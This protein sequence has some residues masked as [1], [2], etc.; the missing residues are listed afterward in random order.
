MKRII[1]VLFYNF[2]LLQSAEVNI[3]AFY[4]VTT[5]KSR[6]AHIWTAIIS[7]RLH[8]PIYE[9][10]SQKTQ[11]ELSWLIHP[12]CTDTGHIFYTARIVWNYRKALMNF[13]SNDT[14]KYA[15]VFED[16][17]YIDT[18]RWQNMNKVHFPHG[19]DAL[20]IGKKH[21]SSSEEF[22]RL[23]GGINTWAIVFSKK[24]ALKFLSLSG[25]ASICLGAIDVMYSSMQ[26][27]FNWNEQ[28]ENLFFNTQFEILRTH[29]AWNGADLTNPLRQ[30]DVYVSQVN[31]VNHKHY[32]TG[33]RDGPDSIEWKEST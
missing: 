20:D 28:K 5:A 12:N 14:M 15:A 2:A 25:Y 8:P 16:D 13:L 27:G 22:V 32:K 21:T 4:L 23:V 29:N 31:Y 24:G 19:A 18:E 30:M 6:R 17:A 1:T 11:F 7:K 9:I 3:D 10:T 26:K 33:D